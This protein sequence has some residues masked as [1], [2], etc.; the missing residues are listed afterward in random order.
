VD[1]A[2]RRLGALRHS[3]RLYS[4]LWA[5]SPDVTRDGEDYPELPTSALAV[6]APTQGSNERIRRAD[7][8][9][10]AVQSLALDAV[11]H[12]EVALD[13]NVDDRAP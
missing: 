6:L 12:G 8:A 4:A 13:V 3:D 9:L 2:E 1:D 10:L 7:W 11:L 5:R